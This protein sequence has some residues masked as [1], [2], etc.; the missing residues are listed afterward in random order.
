MAA[1]WLALPGAALAHEVYVLTPQ[2]IQAAID[3]SSTPILAV[4]REHLGEFLGWL[5]FGAVV[6]L[7]IFLVSIIPALTRRAAP[8]FAKTKPWGP[9]ISRVTIGM[10]FLAAA[11]YQA[12]Y[13]PELPLAATYGAWAP[14]ATAVLVAIGILIILD[15]WVRPAALVALAMFAVAVCFH[16]WYMLTY[17]N[18]L[19]EIAVLLMLGAGAHR[20]MDKVAPAFAVLR[21]LFGTALIYASY[22]AKILY[23]NLALDT[24]NQ[25]HLTRYLGFT[26]HFLV[27]G[28]ATVEIA[29]G[30][31]YILGVEVRFV[32]LFFLFWLTLSLIF[33]GEVVWP[34]LILIGIPIA[35][36]FYG[37]DKYS[38]EGYFFARNGREPVL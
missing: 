1:L 6:V 14:L 2:Q 35:F 37:Y 18:Y 28:A 27:L 11:Y 33:F 38:L 32:S 5:A 8:F 9:V 19:G 25:Y 26:P 17:A 36:F 4:V 13:G 31:F 15:R 29:I 3:T 10:S 20:L 22:Y 23:S 24:V 30:L 34:H 21:V 7:A 16:G 12:T